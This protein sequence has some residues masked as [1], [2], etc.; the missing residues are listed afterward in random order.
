MALLAQLKQLKIKHACM[1]ILQVSAFCGFAWLCQILA[2]YIHSPIPGSV[3]G[4]A[5]LLALLS[6][7]LIPERSVELAATWLIGEL[8][9]FFI[10]PVVAV[11]KYQALLEHFG[12]ILITAMLAASTCVLLGTAFAV[13]KL[14]KFEHKKRLQRQT[15]EVPEHSLQTIRA[16]EKVLSLATPASNSTQKTPEERQAA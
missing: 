11:I 9:L 12:A 8:L 2:T 4:L 10:P 14:F 7:K 5:L 1:L 16:T 3:I 15:A 13:D 6:L